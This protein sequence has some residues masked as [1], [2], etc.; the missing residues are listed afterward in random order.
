MAPEQADLQAIPDARWDVYALGAILY[1]MLT[2]KP[3]HCHDQLVRTIEA[4]PDLASRLRCYQQWIATRRP[5]DDHRKLPG[6]DRA[7]AGIVDR[8]LA[9]RPSKRFANVQEVLDALRARDA[10][11]ARQPL[12]VLGV[13]GPLLLLAVMVLGGYISYDRALGTS[14][15]AVIEKVWQSNAFAA[16]FVAASCATEIQRYFRA[17]ELAAHDEQLRR[18]VTE[19]LDQRAPCSPNWPIRSAPRR[20][21]RSGGA[22][23]SAIPCAGRCRNTS[24]R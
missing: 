21:W 8:C 16:K 12:W 2:G 24:P 6:V 1:C 15:A 11:R 5:P 10:V 19:V 17:V 22:D 14:N 23:L 18:L 9:P 7:L 20:R 3:P 4:A 13:V